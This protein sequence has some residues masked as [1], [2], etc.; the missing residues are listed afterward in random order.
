L[1]W[2][3]PSGLEMDPES[4]TSGYARDLLLYAA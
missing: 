4:E 3:V 2:W 1:L